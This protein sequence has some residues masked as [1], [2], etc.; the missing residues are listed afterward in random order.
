MSTFVALSIFDIEASK[1]K[2]TIPAVVIEIS[3]ETITLREL[4]TRRVE[5]EVARVI[6]GDP[7]QGKPLITPSREERELNGEGRARGILPAKEVA[8]ALSAFERN[9]FFVLAADTK[10]KDPIILSQI[11]PVAST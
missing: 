8:K 5:A 7:L 10:I 4:N 9:R 11:K 2:A 3:S 6:Q 1:P